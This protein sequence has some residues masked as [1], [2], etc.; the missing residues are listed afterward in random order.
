MDA[1]DFQVPTYTPHSVIYLLNER[2]ESFVCAIFL[3]DRAYA[4]AWIMRS[5]LC[6]RPVA[7]RS[8]LEYLERPWE[9]RISALRPK[10][11]QQMQTMTF[12]SRRHDNSPRD[13]FLTGFPLTFK[14]AI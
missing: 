2:A 5:L 7:R 3:M 9:L 12:L 1:L 10:M 6:R 13:R 11:H 8:Q 4:V 14:K